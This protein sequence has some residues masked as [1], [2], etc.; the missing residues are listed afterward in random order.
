MTLPAATQY[1]LPSTPH[2]PNS[3]HRNSTSST[4]AFST[5]PTL[6]GANVRSSHRYSKEFPPIGCYRRLSSSF[7]PTATLEE[8]SSFR[9]DVSCFTL[10]YHPVLHDYQ[11]GLLQQATALV[12]YPQT[13]GAIARRAAVRYGCASARRWPPQ[14]YPCAHFC[15]CCTLAN[16]GGGPFST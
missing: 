7:V 2:S 11:L 16:I 1:S 6:S 15:Y 9:R 5:P 3:A 13:T 10:V 12:L 4:S 8:P 14:R